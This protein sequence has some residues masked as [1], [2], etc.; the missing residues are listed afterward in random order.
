MTVDDWA[1]IRR[2]HRVEKMAIKAIARTL[3]RACTPSALHPPLF[4]GREG[5]PTIQAAAPHAN[6]GK[7]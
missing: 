3:A 7:W 4:S 1:E 2:L 6:R 5:V